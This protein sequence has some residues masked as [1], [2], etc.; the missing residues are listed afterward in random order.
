MIQHTHPPGCS[1]RKLRS[2]NG[3]KTHTYC[4]DTKLPIPSL[5][6]Y[7][8]YW[9]TSIPTAFNNLGIEHNMPLYC[10]VELSQVCHHPVTQHEHF[11]SMEVTL[12]LSAVVLLSTHAVVSFAVYYH[13]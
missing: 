7:I 8:V 10:Y 2:T 3:H 4:T 6:V 13:N 9:E 12:P 11:V 5:Y 1:E